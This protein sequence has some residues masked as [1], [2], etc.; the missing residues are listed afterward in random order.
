M[1]SCYR[2]T[3]H[4]V[5]SEQNAVLAALLTSDLIDHGLGVFDHFVIVSIIVVDICFVSDL[6][7]VVFVIH[8]W[9]NLAVFFDW[10]GVQIKIIIV[11]VVI[12]CYDSMTSCADKIP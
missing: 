4:D 1:T 12:S 3:K 9:W 7:L 10:I 2:G 5:N 6:V 11:V 8:S